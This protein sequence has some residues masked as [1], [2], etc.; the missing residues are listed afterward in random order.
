MKQ[1]PYLHQRINVRLPI[2]TAR[3]ERSRKVSSQPPVIFKSK[4]K[5]RNEALI[6]LTICSSGSLLCVESKDGVHQRLSYWDGVPFHCLISAVFIFWNFLTLGLCKYNEAPP[7]V[8][9]CERSQSWRRD[10]PH[11]PSPVLNVSKGTQDNHVN[12]IAHLPLLSLTP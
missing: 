1:K 4:W 6:I 11:C 2:P 9:K 10:G 3:E 5:L 12:Y 8:S 7:R